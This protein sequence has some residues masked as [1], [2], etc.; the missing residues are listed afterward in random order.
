MIAATHSD[1]VVKLVENITQAVARDIL[2]A[3]MLRLEKN[4]FPVIFSVH[5]EV[6]CEVLEHTQSLDKFCEILCKMPDWS[7]E[8]PIKAECWQGKRYGKDK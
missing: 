3:A 5:D 7:A 8:L 6:V 4:G 2:A 1:I